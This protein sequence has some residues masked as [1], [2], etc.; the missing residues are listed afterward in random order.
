M[1]HLHRHTAVLDCRLSDRQELQQGR[2]Q[3]SNP[4]I[5][6]DCIDCGIHVLL[7]IPVAANDQYIC[8]ACTWLRSIEDPVE[9]ALMRKHLNNGVPE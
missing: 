6:F 4:P 2:W 3:L 9:R 8:A 5:E 7:F 1:L